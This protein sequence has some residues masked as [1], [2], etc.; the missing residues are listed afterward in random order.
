MYVLLIFSFVFT[1]EFTQRD[2]QEEK[3]KRHRN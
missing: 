1:D 2:Q 3:Q